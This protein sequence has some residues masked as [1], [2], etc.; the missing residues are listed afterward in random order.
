MELDEL[1]RQ[2]LDE[3]SAWLLADEGP[4]HTLVTRSRKNAHLFS[5]LIFEKLAVHPLLQ[6]CYLTGFT[7][8]CIVHY[9]RGQQLK[10]SRDRNC[11]SKRPRTTATCRPG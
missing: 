9:H 4:G 3:R 11:W 2:I 7:W 1:A 8:V 10:Q 5:A 6:D